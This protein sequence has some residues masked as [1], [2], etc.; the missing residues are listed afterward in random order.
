M[1]LI[2]A[3]KES[4]MSDGVAIN[5]QSHTAVALAPLLPTD[6]VLIVDDDEEILELAAEILQMLGYDVLTA[7]NG[8]EAVAVLRRNPRVS[9]LFTDIQMP[10]MGGEEL[11]KIAV[12][13][14]A[15]IRVIFTS[16]RC[17]PRADA[18]FLQKPYRTADLVRVFPSQPV[19]SGS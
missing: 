12:A 19:P 1:L 7:R 18:P 5:I 10:L 13:F 11:A 15:N 6:L 9:T 2:I 8:L 14:R 3:A 16:G 4:M 17:R